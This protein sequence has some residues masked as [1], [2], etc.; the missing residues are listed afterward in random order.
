M[1]I[2]RKHFL[3]VQKYFLIVSKIQKT[4]DFNNTFPQNLRVLSVIKT[5]KN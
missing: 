2:I 5:E 4:G 3:N 1:F